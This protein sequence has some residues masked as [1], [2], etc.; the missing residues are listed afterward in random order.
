MPRRSQRSKSK[1]FRKTPGGKTKTHY[2]KGKGSKHECAS[3]GKQLH[4]VPHSRKNFEV[5]NLSKSQRRPSALFG[6]VLCGKCRRIVVEETAKVKHGLKEAGDVSL[7]LKKFV[8]Q[9]MK[10]V[11]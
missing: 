2:F 10:K 1:K 7:S 9:A 11:D 4:G 5:R 3:C 6:G 8:E